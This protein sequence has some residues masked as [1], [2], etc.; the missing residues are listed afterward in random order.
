VSAAVTMDHVE[1]V[2]VT[3]MVA[4]PSPVATTERRAARTP[5]CRA[6]GHGVDH[7]NAPAGVRSEPS[8]VTEKGSGSPM[9]TVFDGAVLIVSASP[10]PES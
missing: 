3:F 9:G 2:A 5:A 4:R 7:G 8:A 1:L 10:V 6:A